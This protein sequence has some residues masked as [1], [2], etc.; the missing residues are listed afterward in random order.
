M[1]KVI[2]IQVIL[3]ALLMITYLQPVY[4]HC[5]TMDGP[6][7][8]DAKKAIEAHNVNYVL[9]WVKPD[10]EKEIKNIYNL[11]MKV[12]I[13]S[14]NAKE[15]A[16]KYFFETVVRIHRQGEGVPYTGI[17]SA[18]TPI[19]KKIQAAD[20]AIEVGNLEPL[21]NFVHKEKFP[22]LQNLF[23]NVMKL[24]NFDVNNVDAGREYVEAYTRFFHFA[25]GEEQ[26]DKNVHNHHKSDQFPHL[27][28]ILVGIFFVTSCIF[29]ILYL[30]L[31]GIVN[32]SN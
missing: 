15:L 28:W 23:N 31:R 26:V 11:V 25:E 16:E 17:K 18:G 21:K 13:C 20:K 27:S 9:K 6:V 4:S 32:G 7:V 5:D 30:R 3:I 10:F 8:S 14:S 22:E 29:L 12:R 19:D 24:K 1:K 2:I